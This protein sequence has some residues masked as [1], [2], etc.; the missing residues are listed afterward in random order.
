MKKIEWCDFC[1][2]PYN[3]ERGWTFLSSVD[4]S[5]DYDLCPACSVSLGMYIIKKQ[6]EKPRISNQS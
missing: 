2:T 3:G 4:R 5:F 1:K 6:N